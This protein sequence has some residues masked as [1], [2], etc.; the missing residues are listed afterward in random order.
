ME[1]VSKSF[2]FG[3]AIGL[4]SCY[5]GFNSGS[6]ASGV[7]RACTESF[8]SSF[9]VIIML[10]FIFAQMLREMYDALYAYHGIFG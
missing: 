4:I 7:G 10:N 5:K 1:G 6:G 8:V 2:F 3:A 9:I